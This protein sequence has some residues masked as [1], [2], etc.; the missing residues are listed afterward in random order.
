MRKLLLILTFYRSFALVSFIITLACVS[1]I[2]RNGISTLTVLIWFKM[3]T[4]ALF[5]YYISSYKR[6]EMYY[7]KNLGVSPQALWIPTLLFD[8]VLCLVLMVLTI[9]IK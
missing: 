9:K 3:A 5:F 7:Y 2:Y 6:N 1:I 4:L 8:F